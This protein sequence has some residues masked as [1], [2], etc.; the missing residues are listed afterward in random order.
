MGN[1]SGEWIMYGVSSDDPMCIHN[2]EELLEFVDAAGF[3]PL[4][5]NEIPGFSLEE[6]TVPEHWWSDD[7]KIDPW[8]WRMQAAASHKVAYGKFFQNKAGF[9]SL[10]WLPRFVNWRRDGYDFDA[11]W[12][13]GKAN[14]RLKKI[15][16]VFD[17]GE[18][19]LSPTLK[20]LAGFGK[21]GEKN[22]EGTVTALMMR[23]Y[24]TMGDFRRRRN[25]RGE[26]YG[27]SIAVYKRP[28]DIWGYDAVTSAY[29]EAPEDS[30]TACLDQIASFFRVKDTAK[31]KKFM[32]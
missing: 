7:A 32:K 14:Y 17:S 24:L 29:D 5:K 9:I 22:Y 6:R 8:D 18:G 25:R 11:L 23:T 27:W 19:F 4:F 16:D 2:I 21:D 10:K 1:E 30:R 28:E 12:D 31:L 20:E 3:L 13:D 15:M 26:E